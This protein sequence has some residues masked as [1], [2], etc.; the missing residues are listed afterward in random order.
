MTLAHPR[1]SRLNFSV[2]ATLTG[3][4]ATL[5]VIGAGQGA[6]SIVK[7]GQIRHD[8]TE[9]AANW[10]PSVVAANAISLGVDQ[11]RIKQYR[12]VTASTDAGKLGEHRRQYDAAL[13]TLAGWGPDA[14]VTETV[15]G[16]ANMS[17]CEL[18]SHRPASL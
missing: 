10:L 4:F 17:T 18:F 3:L 15:C 2:K 14:P 12:L 13:A 1:R 6:L 11:V 16:T 7:L 8:V 5:A 9:V